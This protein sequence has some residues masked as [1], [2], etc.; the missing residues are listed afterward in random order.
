MM[1]IN[2][3]NYIEMF[4]E[5]FKKTNESFDDNKKCRSPIIERRNR[6]DKINIWKDSFHLGNTN[7]MDKNNDQMYN[8]YKTNTNVNVYFP[9]KLILKIILNQLLKIEFILLYFKKVVLEVV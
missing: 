6:G 1:K 4:N 3:D 5:L 2:Q 8:K 9:K 7:N